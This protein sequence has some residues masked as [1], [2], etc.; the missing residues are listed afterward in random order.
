MGA[1]TARRLGSVADIAF[2]STGIADPTAPTAAEVNALTRI[3]CDIA[4][5]RSWP[6]SAEMNKR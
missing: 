4:G 3:E 2:G 1:K 5:A 6:W